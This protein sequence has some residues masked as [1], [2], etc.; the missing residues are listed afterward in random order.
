MQNTGK[1]RVA[2]NGYG[3]IG[4]RVADAVALQPDME[5][6]GI[7]DVAADWR[8]AVA[9]QRGYPIFAAND[10]AGDAMCAAGLPVSGALADMLATADVVVDA[11]P[12]AI[13]TANIAAYQSAG[14]K[15][16]V[17]GGEKHAA[18]GHSFV[19]EASYL[20]ALNR[21]STRVVSCNTTSIVRTLTALKQA[22]LLGKARGVLLRRATDPWESHLGGIMNTLVP[23][24]AIPSHQGPDAQSV[25]PD[26]DLVTM[27]VKVPQTLG[28]LH[29]WSVTLT[30]PADR[31]EVLRAFRASSRIL[32]L[33]GDAGFGALN[34]V[35]EW[36][37][38][39]H[40]PRSD[41]YEVALWEDML[42]VQGDELFY[43]YMVDNQAIVVPETIDALRVICGLQT[44]PA[45]SIQM[46]D[47]ALGIGGLQPLGAPV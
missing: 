18:T 8:I 46:T 23:E 33:R 15:F 7:A 40:R 28:H 14:L 41:L 34:T 12:K 19:A 27:A 11:T 44:D 30:R 20:T 24:P 4:K 26:L 43:A 42:T 9:V 37:Q 5:V 10:L 13:A 2:V 47:A 29:Y 32:L 21:Q 6:A 38:D 31:D 25:D 17:Q 1:L 3:V 16:I 22:A 45:T 39:T 36:M 35:K